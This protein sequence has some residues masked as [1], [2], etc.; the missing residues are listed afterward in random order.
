MIVF[1]GRC[2]NPWVSQLPVDGVEKL[3]RI[4]H[5]SP[6]VLLCWLMKGAG[7]VDREFGGEY[8]LQFNWGDDVRFYFDK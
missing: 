8:V 3:P 5:F 4:S 2:G 7:T 6:I 1:L